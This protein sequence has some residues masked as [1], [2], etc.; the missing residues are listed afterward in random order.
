MVSKTVI[1]MMSSLRTLAVSGDAW[2]IDHAAGRPHRRVKRDDSGAT[3]PLSG[4]APRRSKKQR[5]QG[6]E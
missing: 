2:A 3:Q 5:A 6:C 4:V 1:T